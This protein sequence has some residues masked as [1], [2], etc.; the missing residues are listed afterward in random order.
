MFFFERE[1]N[2]EYFEKIEIWVVVIKTPFH[3]TPVKQDSTLHSNQSFGLQF[4][5]QVQERFVDLT[6]RKK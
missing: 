2:K 6:A 1:K 5:L 3:K 4:W